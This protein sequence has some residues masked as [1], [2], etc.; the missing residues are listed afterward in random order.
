MTKLLGQ[1]GDFRK[2]NGVSCPVIDSGFQQLM[3]A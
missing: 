1:C 3:A 2:L